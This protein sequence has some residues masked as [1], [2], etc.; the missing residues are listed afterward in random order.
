MAG[1]NSQRK[2]SEYTFKNFL[3]KCFYSEKFRIVFIGENFCLR[4]LTLIQLL[5]KKPEVKMEKIPILMDVDTG[6]DDAIALIV[7]LQSDKL[8]IK[9][10]TAVAG[11]QTLDKTLKNT[12]DVVSFA[13]RK[14]IPVARGAEKPLIRDQ[15][16]AREVHGQTGLGSAVL[17][18]SDITPCR[19][20]AI[21]L[22]RKIL[23][24]SDKKVT[25]VPTGPLTDVALLLLAY[26]DVKE[27]IEK[28]VM[29]GGGAFQGN[30]TPSAEFN[31]WVDPEAASVVFSSGLP[32]V[33]CGL[34]VTMKAYVTKEDIEKIKAT[35][36]KAGLFCADAFSR[37]YDWYIATGR[38]P[39]CAVHDAVTIAYL[40]E[41][42]IISAKPAAV[43]VDIDGKYTYGCTACDFRPDRDK[44]LDNALVCLDIDREAFVELLTKACKN[45][46]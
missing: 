1:L 26:P 15:I 46:R 14:D 30:S 7:A 39:G 24:E 27:K 23:D 31:I 20:D 29:M 3:T 18:P 42:E 11:N 45:Y 44:N 16:I 2:I 5:Q 33:L 17:P 10:I 34:D 9:G 13:G 35:G 40:I 6:I 8:D 12:L 37:Y 43:K 25:L 41:P 32:I 22:M 28:I 4:L 19:L 21:S 36:T 38:L